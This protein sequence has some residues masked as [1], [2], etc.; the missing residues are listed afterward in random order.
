MLR[1]NMNNGKHVCLSGCSDQYFLLAVAVYC[2][3]RKLCF[4]YSII[5]AQEKLTNHCL[6]LGDLLEQA[7]T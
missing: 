1:K 4:Y 2:L 5:T 7:I 6:S 3:P